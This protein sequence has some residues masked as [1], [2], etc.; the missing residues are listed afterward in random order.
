MGRCEAQR[1]V[2]SDLGG[3]FVDGTEHRVKHDES[4]DEDGDDDAFHAG[5]R[6]DAY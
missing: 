3:A 4:R 2:D 6:G 1:A 5:E